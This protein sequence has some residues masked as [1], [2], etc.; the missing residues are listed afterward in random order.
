MLGDLACLV[1]RL[2]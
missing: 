1:D 2:H